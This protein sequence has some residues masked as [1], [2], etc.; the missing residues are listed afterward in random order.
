M[1]LQEKVTDI[2]RRLKALKN[3]SN[4]VIWGA[5]THTCKLFEYTDILSYQVQSILDTDVQKQGNLYFGFTIQDPEEI[6]WGD[7]EAVV[8]SVFGKETQIINALVNQYGY[9]ERIVT[10][11]ENNESTP[12]YFLFDEK[13]S[14]VRYFGNYC[15]W[16]EAL[17]ECN[18]YDDVKILNKV[19]SAVDKVVNGDAVWERDGC[20]FY[21]HKYVYCICAPLLRCALRNQNRGVRIL[22]I[23]GALGSTYFQNKEYLAE[24]KN[25][26]YIVVE[27]D[28]FV[29]YG[30]HNLENGTLK[31]IKSLEHWEKLDKLDI[32]LLSASLQYISQ[33]QEVISKI[34]KAQPHYI[35]LDR[36]LVSDKMRICRET[37]PECIYE[38]SYPLRIFAENQIENFFVF[39]YKLIEQDIASVPENPYF[40]DGR[41][42]SRFYV[43]ELQK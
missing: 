22:D 6:N 13:V 23:G 37:V 28:H 7:V 17:N 31:F 15:N 40:V 19:I 39:D 10:L 41:A 35:I 2:N 1:F 8:I 30:Q 43:F 33:Y 3:I 14:A 9:T 29:D 4:I 38:G 36:I 25:L 26:E 24:I 32:I 18:G 11:Y 16:D 34:M 27:Q 42:V 20:L 5:G 12:F 21:E